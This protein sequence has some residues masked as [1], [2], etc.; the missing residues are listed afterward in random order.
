MQFLYKLRDFLWIMQ[1]YGILQLTV[2]NL[3]IMYWQKPSEMWSK[4]WWPRK[5]FYDM[6]CKQSQLYWSYWS[7]KMDT[8]EFCIIELNFNIY[9]SP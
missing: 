7:D 2:E 9:Y 8:P 1:L 6:S 5:Q 4:G 3:T